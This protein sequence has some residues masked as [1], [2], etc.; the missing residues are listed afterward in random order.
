MARRDDPLQTGPATRTRTGAVWMA[1]TLFVVFV[2]LLIVFIAQNNRQVP[3]HF[4]GMSGTVSESVAL[5][6]AAVGGAL[7][8]VLIGTARILQLRLAARRTR[9]EL[10]RQTN[11]QQSPAPARVEPEPVETEDER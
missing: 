6:A 4:L 1:I 8:V 9:R 11:A 2:V 3:L 10:K 5:V 7:L